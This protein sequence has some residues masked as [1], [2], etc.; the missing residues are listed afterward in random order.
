MYA[1]FP[2]RR[3]ATVVN[4]RLHHD[5]RISKG[6][7]RKER[8]ENNRRRR[9]TRQ[10]LVL[11][12]TV[13]FSVC[14]FRLFLS[15]TRRISSAN[16]H[17]QDSADASLPI[18]YSRAV[19]QRVFA[20]TL[21]P[22][23]RRSF[24]PRCAA[25]F[26]AFWRASGGTNDSIF[27]RSPFARDRSPARVIPRDG[28]ARRRLFVFA[29]PVRRRNVRIRVPVK[30]TRFCFCF[31][32]TINPIPGVPR[33]ANTKRYRN[34]G[35]IERVHSPAPNRHYARYAWCAHI[36]LSLHRRPVEISLKRVYNDFAIRLFF[37][38]L[39]IYINP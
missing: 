36:I 29:P 23:G 28:C 31:F 34:A 38:N 25:E 24:S 8:V 5:G 1:I 4:T 3:D 14:F 13:F 16:R 19:P 2:R 35:G 27:V 37:R 30:T 32:R 26:P 17:T 6:D 39:K 18:P 22:D 15:R 20:E 9:T 33:V 21:A 12:S 10:F 7:N 11:D